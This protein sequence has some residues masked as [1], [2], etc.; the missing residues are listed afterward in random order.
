[1]TAP[2][3]QRIF[4][5]PPSLSIALGRTQRF[6][7]A[8]QFSD[9]TIQ[10]FT[11]AVTWASSNTA[12]GT[13]LNTTGTRGQ[14]TTRL[15]GSTFVSALFPSGGTV[16]AHVVVTPAVVVE[17]TTSGFSPLP[18]GTVVQCGAQATYSDGQVLTVT[19]RATWTSSDE[20]VATISNASGSHGRITTRGVGSTTIRATVDGFTASTELFVTPPAIASLVVTPRDPQAGG[21][22]VQFTATGTFT[23]AHVE[24]VTNMVSWGSSDRTRVVISNTDGSRGLATPVGQGQ[25]IITAQSGRVF[26]STVMTVEF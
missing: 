17:M 5:D 10:D 24:N 20:T 18:R 2:V 13:I 12:V 22:L 25:V 16:F 9:G 1:V 11:T 6:H 3:L 14:F 19:D 7:A 15:P 8:G 26:A 23:D 21:A 4:V